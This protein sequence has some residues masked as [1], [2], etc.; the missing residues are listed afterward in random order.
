[1]AAGKSCPRGT[2]ASACTRR[3]TL[4]GSGAGAVASVNGA[5]APAD[6][7]RRL[8]PRDRA[9]QRSA[10]DLRGRRRLLAVPGRAGLRGRALSGAL[11][12]V[13]PD[14]QPLSPAAAA[15]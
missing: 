6:L 12:R 1:M 15:P 13:L 5:T 7:S 3:E 4:A 14:V 2:R 9:G 10:D 11:S 8:L